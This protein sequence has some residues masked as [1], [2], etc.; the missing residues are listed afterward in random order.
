[1]VTTVRDRVVAKHKVRLTNQMEVW[2]SEFASGERTGREHET[3]ETAMPSPAGFRSFRVQSS[4]PASAKTMGA[5]EAPCSSAP[6][7]PS[8]SSGAFSPALSQPPASAPTAPA[9]KRR[10]LNMML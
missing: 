7:Q 10:R 6:S 4:P 2:L 3:V 9:G 5:T 8:P 1:M